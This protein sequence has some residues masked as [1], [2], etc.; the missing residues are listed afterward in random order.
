MSDPR[1]MSVSSASRFPSDSIGAS[2]NPASAVVMARSTAAD[3]TCSLDPKC[4]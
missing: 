3:S 4:A 1:A 2:A